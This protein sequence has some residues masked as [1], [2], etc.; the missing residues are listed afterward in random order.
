MDSRIA[1]TAALAAGTRTLDTNALAQIGA[2]SGGTG[3]GLVPVQNNF[4]D[5]YTG[6]QLIVVAPN[7]GLIIAN[8]TAM[9]ASGVVRLYA[10]VE[11]A[12]ASAF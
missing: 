11:F 8:L 9:G 4:W 10:N 2:W 7:E 1:T 12:I 3:Q 6:N 5:Q